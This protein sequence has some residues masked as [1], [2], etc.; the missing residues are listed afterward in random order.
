MTFKSICF[1]GGG[2]LGFLHIGVLQKLYEE[3]QLDDIEN[4]FGTSIGGVIGLLFC[5]KLTPTEIYEKMLPLD[6]T[7]LK[8]KDLDV[9]FETMGMENADYFMAHLVD[10]LISCDISPRITFAE[11]YE[12][13]E[14]HL[15]VTGTNLSTHKPEYYNHI[16]TP[17]FRVLH[18]IRRTIS[19]PI[20]ISPVKVQVSSE[21]SSEISTEKAIEHDFFVDGGVTDNFPMQACYEHFKLKYESVPVVGGI[22]GCMI[23]SLI[24]KPIKTMEDYLYNLLACCIKKERHVDKCLEQCVIF[25]STDIPSVDFSANEEKRKEMFLSGY[26]SAENYLTMMK[27]YM[28]NDVSVNPENDK[29]L[30]LA[31]EPV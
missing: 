26:S 10:I 2:V 8:Y 1:S 18:A 14:K 30:E 9:I 17:D 4:I 12:K 5:I 3:N 20:I 27:K 6:H 28:N 7:L 11:L 31:S 25:A 22:I 13:T 15:T 24:P 21:N 16:T 23:D 19:F 29:N